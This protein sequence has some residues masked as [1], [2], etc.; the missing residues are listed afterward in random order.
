MTDDASPENLRKFLESDDPALVRMGLSMAK[1]TESPEDYH[2]TLLQTLQCFLKSE[3]VETVKTGIMLAD[4]AGI[5]DEAMDM[6]CEPLIEALGK[7]DS[8][9]RREAAGMLGGIGDTRAVE[10]LIKALGDGD[11]NVRKA[12]VEILRVLGDARA[13]Q[14][15]IKALGGESWLDGDVREAA[16]KALEEVLEKVGDARAVP[17]L[18]KALKQGRSDMAPFLEKMPP[19]AVGAEYERLELY[20]DAEE[21][22]TSHGML[23]EAAAVR[24]KKAEMGAAKTEIHGDYVDDR[25]IIIKDSVVSKSNIGAGGDDKFAKLDRL[26]EMKEKGLI[27][28]AEFQQMKKEIL[29]K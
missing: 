4:E 16:A 6:L 25:D 27:D 24:R 9:I 19:A 8:D 28:D 23:E 15:L 17:S 12:A 18:I 26:A 2:Q 13:V 10:P 29:E 3:D 20:D 11:R 5:G 14:P 7:K 22:Y 1:G 21:W